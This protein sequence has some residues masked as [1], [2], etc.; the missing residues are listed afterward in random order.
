MQ[1][2]MEN[3]VTNKYHGG[4]FKTGGHLEKTGNRCD[5]FELQVINH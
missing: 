3:R 2:C 5:G 4:Q 1:I